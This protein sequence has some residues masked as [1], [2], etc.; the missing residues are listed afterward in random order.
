MC[1]DAIDECR[2][3]FICFLGERYGW[4]QN[5]GFPTDECLEETFN[6]AQQKYPW[7]SQY[8]DRGIVEM[9]ILYGVLQPQLSPVYKELPPEETECHRS[10]FYFRDPLSITKRFELGDP[11]RKNFEEESSDGHR[12]LREL[13]DRIRDT[14]LPLVDGY[15]LDKLSSL[16]MNNLLTSLDEDFPEDEPS[17]KKHKGPS[18]H[19]KMFYHPNAS[20]NQAMENYIS[21][22]ISSSK[23]NHPFIVYGGEGTGKSTVLMHWLEGRPEDMEIDSILSYSIM[24][25][26]PTPQFVASS[27]FKEVSKLYSLTPLPSPDGTDDDLRLSLQSL[28][29]AVAIQ[30]AQHHKKLV[31][32][33]PG[34]HNLA[35]NYWFPTN[36]PSSI[37]V[38]LTCKKLEIL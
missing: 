21:E 23:N 35:S 31:I 6:N 29:D 27:I 3:Y 33:I 36:I 9:E 1:L 18:T 25:S 16:I 11:E 19:A 22:P 15:S 28:F 13:K 12:K 4:S 26:S 34:Y 14:K 38:F 32:A 20:A 2:P 17:A 8:K 5:E 37:R 30:L 10:F 7:V 24:D